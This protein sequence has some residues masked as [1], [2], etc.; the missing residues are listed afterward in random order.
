MKSKYILSIVVAGAAA[1]SAFAQAS[2]SGYFIDNY[3][4]RYMLN[5][6]MADTVRKGFVAFPAL[7]SLNVGMHGNVGVNSLVYNVDGRTVL[8]TNPGVE[9]STVLGKIHDKNRIGA[10]VNEDILAVGWKAW[11]GNNAI[12]ISAVADAEVMMPGSL[13]RLAKEGVENK[14]YD[15][16]NLRA[17]ANAYA[18]IQLNHSRDIKQVPGLRAGAAVKFLLGLGNVDMYMN[19]AYLQLN[20]DSW[21]IRTNADVY[22]N[23][24][25]ATFKQ[26]YSDKTGRFYVDGL[27]IDGI[28]LNGFGLGFDLGATYEWRDFRFSLAMLDLGFMSWSNTLKASTNGYREVATSDYTFSIGSDN[29]D[30]DGRTEWDKLTDD[31]SNLYQLEDEGH[32]GGRTTGLR[33]T[34]NWGVEYILPYYRNLSFGMV[35]TTKFNGSF[36]WTDFRFSANV[37]P[38]KCLAA[39]VNFAAG[40]YGVAFGWLLNLNV[41]GF[42]MFAGMDRTVGKLAKQ[43]IPL[44]SN[45]EVS[46]G[47]NFPF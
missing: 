25:N 16:K 28:G 46:F 35:N 43:G 36:T 20:E 21:N 41:K 5:P 23:I 27:D 29:K 22:A 26:K 24:K 8:F 4:H 15:I 12:T 31:L 44:N 39:S 40:T 11:G 3:T 6:A 33:A 18:Q 38:V 14:T 1:G 45:A 47:I 34:L 30:D 32:T 19:E 37:H 42:N 10:A 7:G 9:A 2:Y 17:T 13:I